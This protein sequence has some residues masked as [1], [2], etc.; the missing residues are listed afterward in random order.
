M[1]PNYIKEGAYVKC[2]NND[3]Y[4][5]GKIIGIGGSPSPDECLLTIQT[6]PGNLERPIN[7]EYVT[8]IKLTTDYL[9]KFGFTQKRV[10]NYD[11]FE[12]GSLIFAKALFKVDRFML[13]TEIRLL[14]SINVWQDV[15]KYI[16]EQGMDSQAFNQDFRKIE[17]INLVFDLLLEHRIPTTP[18]EQV[19]LAEKQ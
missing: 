18:I 6:I 10:F 2:L 15:T 12:K 17:D 7:A 14:S 3:F 4:N 5:Y 16:S 13:N 1:N 8:S 19:L 11:V 9:V